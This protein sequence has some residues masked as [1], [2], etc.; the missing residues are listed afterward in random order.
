MVTLTGE[1]GDISYT[2]LRGE[3][4]LRDYTGGGEQ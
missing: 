1:E 2:R 4:H 3:S